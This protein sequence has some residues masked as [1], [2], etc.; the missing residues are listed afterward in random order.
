LKRSL[1]CL[2]ILAF[3]CTPTVGVFEKNVAI[4][5]HSWSSSF[6][7]EVSFEIQSD[8]VSL[9]R[10]YVVLRHTDA[11]NYKNIWLNVGVQSPGDSMRQNRLNLVLANDDKGWLGKG[12]DDVYEHRIP[13]EATPRSFPKPGIYKFTL[14][15][16]M[17]EDPLQHVMNAGIRLEKVPG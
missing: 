13:L 14:Q 2:L 17:R 5:D 3:G 9:Y 10:L 15:Q 16:I 12:M 6:K 4:P 11:Y 1:Y 8:T 7:P